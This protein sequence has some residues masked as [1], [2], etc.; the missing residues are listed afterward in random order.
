[1][2]RISAEAYEALADALAR[3]FW[4]KPVFERCLRRA[5]REH[6]ELL[7]GLPFG[8]T[9]RV[10]CDELVSKLAAAE[11][12]YRDFTLSLMLEVGQRKEFPDLVAQKDKPELLP[13]GEAAVAYLR[14]LTA[15]YAQ[16]VSEG[17]RIRK[18]AEAARADAALRRSF[19][20]RLERLRDSFV[21][22]QSAHDVHQ[23]GRDLERLLYELFA[24]YDLEP[25]LAYNEKSDQIDGSFSFDTDDYI[26][27]AK[28]L[29]GPADK[30]D[31][32]GLMAKVGRQGKNGLGLFV[33]V[34]GFTKGF[35][36]TYDRATPF[37]TLDGDDLFIILSGLMRLDD[38]LRLKKRH[39]NESGSCYY[40][41]RPL[42]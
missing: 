24:L 18:R 27:E 14:S 30:A 39:A 38:A 31:A 29:A 10:V 20:S 4:R 15:P 26:L 40:P 11:H 35:R 22:M 16:H 33:S 3:S 41:I 6:P 9:K 7:G 37:L 12:R 28:W 25:R 42:L 8:D 34:N 32:D 13:A 19:E 36:E 23:R 5:L 2:H 21:A 1:M 17:E